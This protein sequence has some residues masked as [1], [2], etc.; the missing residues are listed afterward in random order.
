MQIIREVPQLPAGLIALRAGGN[1]LALVP[2]MGALHAGHMALI[3]E[4]KRRADRVAG[5]IF[6][7]DGAIPIQGGTPTVGNTTHLQIV[8]G[9]GND[10][11]TLNETNGRLPGAA[12]F[13]LSWAG[14]FDRGDGVRQISAL[15]LFLAQLR[16]TAPRAPAR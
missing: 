14:P 6:V 16:T 1:S 7:N 5:T 13:G 11:I 10:S 12:L 8:G 2:T 9:D 15:D 4:A 3:H